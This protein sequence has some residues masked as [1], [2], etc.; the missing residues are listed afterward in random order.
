M[1]VIIAIDRDDKKPDIDTLISCE[2]QNGDGGGIAWVEG[3]KVFWKK[4][5]DAKEIFDIMS[6]KKAPIV[7]HFRIATAGGK[8]KE[9]CHPFPISA[10]TALALE[11]QADSV[12]F[13]NG[14]WNYYSET[15]ME[16]FQYEFYIDKAGRKTKLRL[17]YGAWSDSRA[18]AWLCHISNGKFRKF[19]DTDLK[20]QKI[21]VLSAKEGIVI[22]GKGWSR[23]DGISYSNKYW[24]R[25]YYSSTRYYG[26]GESAYD[27][28]DFWGRYTGENCGQVKC[29]SCKKD[30]YFGPLCYSCEDELEKFNIPKKQIGFSKNRKKKLSKAGLSPCTDC[31]TVYIK[32]YKESCPLCKSLKEKKSGESV[33]LPIKREDCSGETIWKYCK[34]CSYQHMQKGDICIRC[35][36]R[37]DKKKEIIQ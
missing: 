13:H 1:C 5:I 7:I 27:D 8:S 17:P 34:E 26:R 35:Q 21:A 33:V 4:G 16:Q 29:A 11:G 3:D 28:E 37:I 31:D 18:M 10:N 24:N 14:H 32:E 25:A 2:N 9:L 12:L 15:V 20:E 6:E 36:L 19:F 23:E 22:T 30:T